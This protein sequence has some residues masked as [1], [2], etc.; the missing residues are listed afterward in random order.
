MRQEKPIQPTRAGATGPGATGP[1]VA[2]PGVGRAGLGAACAGLEAD[3]SAFVDG[4]LDAIRTEYIVEHLFDCD[5][6]QR[7]V[8]EM[9][10]LA[11]LHR[12]TTRETEILEGFDGAEMF[13]GI[14]SRLID[15]KIPKIADLFYQIGK[16]YIIKGMQAKKHPRVRAI[17]KDE[18]GKKAED[19]GR[20]GASWNGKNGGKPIRLDVRTP[21]VSLDRS[22]MKTGRL[23]R[24]LDGLANAGVSN[25][26]STSRRAH[27]KSHKKAQLFFRKNSRRQGDYLDLGR[28]F[29]E[30]SLAID[31]D[32]AEPRLYLGAYFYVAKRNYDKGKEQFR[33]VLALPE[34]SEVNR[35]EALINLGSIHSILY[36]YHDAVACFLD[37]ATSGILLDH[38]RFYRSL[39]FLAIS[40]AK[41]G[42]YDASVSAFSR[43][44]DEFPKQAEQIKNELWDMHSF[45]RVVDS[46]PGFKKHLEERVP[47]LFAS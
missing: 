40:Y 14:T 46:Q 31:G 45:Q 22:K 19:S 38:P 32:R 16:A 10:N 18:G 33:K 24:E 6:C 9:S 35:A 36:E 20:S 11:R 34:L 47:V 7:F 12:S 8:D 27:E 15:D 26:S 44:V 28:A 1:G 23:F 37:V 29:L 3:L 5:G 21:P 30:E 43:T 17:N 42:E 2:G 39:V 41:I 13:S 4:E 25:G